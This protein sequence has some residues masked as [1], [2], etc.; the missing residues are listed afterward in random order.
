MLNMLQNKEKGGLGVLREHVGH[1][2]DAANEDPGV[3][4]DNEEEDEFKVKK[5]F[6]WCSFLDALSSLA[7]KLSVTQSVIL[8]SDL[9]SIQSQQSQ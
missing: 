9:Q 5:N 1:N 7:F 6:I 4:S 2:E 8:F 3:N